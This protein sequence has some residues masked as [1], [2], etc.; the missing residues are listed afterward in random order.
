MKKVLITGVSGFVGSYLANELN[1]DRNENYEIYGTKL[2]NENY[3]SIANIH[4]INLDLTDKDRVHNV[5]T[6]IKPDIVFHL[7]AQSSVKLSW[8]DPARTAKINIIG[9]INLL[10]ELRDVNKNCKILLVGSSEE[11]GKTFSTSSTPEENEKCL[12]QNIYAITKLTQNYIGSLYAKVYG[13]NIIMT[14]SYNH[15]GPKQSPQFVVADFCNQVA[16]IENGLQDSIIRVGNLSSYRDF[17]DVRDIVSAYYK[18]IQTGKSGET[19][20]V[21][22]GKSIKIEEILNRLIQ[23]SNCNIDV[24]VDP[25]KFRPIDIVE[26]KANIE[27]LKR[28]TDWHQQHSIDDTLIETLNYFRDYYTRNEELKR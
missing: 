22:S 6:E 27:K 19:Y 12:P 20:N 16:R 18:L 8:D 10:E 4:T 17:L 5:I 13:M 26:T 15:F 11:Y 3:N 24:I 7:A 9:T 2:T 21:G 14:R 1:F 25:N 23:L 28:D